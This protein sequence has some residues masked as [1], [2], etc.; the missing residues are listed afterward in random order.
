MLREPTLS[1][2]HPDA[3]FS[4]GH[5][6]LSR[7]GLPATLTY[8]PGCVEHRPSVVLF[9]V[10]R[11]AQTPREHRTAGPIASAACTD[12]LPL[13]VRPDV[14]TT[15]RV[16]IPSEDEYFVRRPGSIP[17]VCAF[18]PTFH[19]R[20]VWKL[21]LHAVRSR[22]ASS[23]NSKREHRVSRETSG[24]R[25]ITRRPDSRLVTGSQPRNEPPPPRP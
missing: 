3:G 9:H 4:R 6:D 18:R 10:K 14:Q 11:T 1:G 24:D 25:S 17:P 22:E 2:S 20:P 12:F 16:T 23:R 13:A 5:E 8:W 21:G 19:V 7:F 15:S